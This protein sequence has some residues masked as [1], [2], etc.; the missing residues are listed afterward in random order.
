LPTARTANV[1]TV[2]PAVSRLLRS[3]I[4]RQV[5]MRLRVCVTAGRRVSVS[6]VRWLDANG[7][8]GERNRSCPASHVS[9]AKLPVHGFG[10][11][12]RDRHLLRHLSPHLWLEPALSLVLQSSS[13][14]FSCR[15][16]KRARPLRLAV[17]PEHIYRRCQERPH[18]SRTS[19]PTCSC[20]LHPTRSDAQGS[21]DSEGD[22]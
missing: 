15:A 16:R 20:V 13:S 8:E 11:S 1:V 9:L 3:D 4:S 10:S 18:T 5:S 12:P 21:S 14:L 22:S 17:V 7:R 2:R 19:A 6:G